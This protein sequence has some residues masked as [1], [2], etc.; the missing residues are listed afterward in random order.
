MFPGVDYQI[1]AVEIVEPARDGVAGTLWTNA[2]RFNVGSHSMRLR[3]PFGPG[4]QP[5]IY[6]TE[7]ITKL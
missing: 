6:G 3:P 1:A 7:S 2:R 5:T 4:F